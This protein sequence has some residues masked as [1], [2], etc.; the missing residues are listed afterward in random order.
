MA[1]FKAWASRELRSKPILRD[2]ILN[3]KDILTAEEFFAKS[4]IW[5]HILELEKMIHNNVQDI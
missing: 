3:E 5:L 1:G 2:I 4:E